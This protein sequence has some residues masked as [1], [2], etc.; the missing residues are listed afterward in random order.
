MHEDP[1]VDNY[2]IR[3]NGKKL[4]PGMVICIEPMICQGQRDIYVDDDKW[5][6]H[7]Q[8]HKLAA[9]YEH[10]VLIKKGQPELLSSYDLIKEVL[11]ER[12]I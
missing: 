6:V 12:F 4:V 9:H 3:G 11:K 5:T 7:T 2:G 10:C 8:D 1:E